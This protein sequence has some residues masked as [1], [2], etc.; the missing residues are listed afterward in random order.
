MTTQAL[1][2]W[3][4]V[5]YH[6]AAIDLL[7]EGTTEH[8]LFLA[9]EAAGAET[10][11]AEADIA[12]GQPDASVVKQS[13][14][15]RWIQLDSAGYEKFDHEEMRSALR[16][17][18]ALLTN[19]SSVYDEPC[20]QHLLAMITGLARRLPEALINQHEDKSWP[21]MRLRAESYLLTGQTVL[22]LGFG[23]IAQRLAELLEPL[24]MNL[25]AV[26]RQPTGEETILTV[27]EAE[28]EKY[29][30]HADHV[31]N[32]LPANPGTRHFVNAGRLSLMKRGAIFYNVGRGGTVDQNGLLAALISGHLAAAYLDVTD[33]EPLPPDHPLWTTSN[34]F[35][36]PHTA[37][38]HIG[39]KERLV[40][41]FLDN[42]RRFTSGENLIDLII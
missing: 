33:P 5:K 11:L 34:C 10:R 1:K 25:I 23:A 12:F 32:T 28:A 26:R 40:R 22:F 15:L 21:M 8:Q 9:A 18:E 41:H 4:N 35:I 3:S 31:I 16:A 39:E 37:G 20:A 2:I 38:G 36:T 6:D 19:S 24:H 14:D 29:L 27:A 17:R 13:A 42:L 30:P 7:R